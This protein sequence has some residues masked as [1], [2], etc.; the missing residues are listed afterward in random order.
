MDLIRKLFWVVLTVVFTFGFVVLFENGPTN[1]LDNAKV[2]FEQ[3]KIMFA[4]KPK[5]K[6]D[7]SDQLK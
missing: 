1:Y 5:A 7:T 3:M 2:E 6:G 4:T